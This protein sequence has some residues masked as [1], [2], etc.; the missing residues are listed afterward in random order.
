MCRE[1]LSERL[2]RRTGGLFFTQII[3]V[4]V[5]SVRF[6]VYL[7]RRRRCYTAGPMTNERTTV[8]LPAA[9]AGSAA[10]AV[11]E[12]TVGP[13]DDLFQRLYATLRA[14]AERMMSHESSGV[15]LQATAVVHEAYL[16]L[17]GPD[18]RRMMDRGLFCHA[19]AEEMRRV[20]IDHARARGARKRGGGRRRAI[21]NVMDLLESP[22]HSTT[23][24]LDDALHE[25]GKTSA[26]VAA[27]V[28]LRFYAGLSVDQTADALGRSPRS[29]DR[30]WAYAR[31][32]LF[33]RLGN[34]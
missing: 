17:V 19:I 30:D 7:T 11:D 14:I 15:T 4:K 27:V 12:R 16:R 3:N 20:L 1:V 33:D 10:V 6:V 13:V 26:D 8:P 32:W 29:I 2:M 9:P 24:E 28:R 23:I 22:T 21:G 25:L 34:G 18:P 31:A 5:K